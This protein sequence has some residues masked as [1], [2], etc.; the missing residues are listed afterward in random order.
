MAI[1]KKGGP[2]TVAGKAI[3]AKNSTKHGLTTQTPSSP[4]EKEIVNGYIQDLTAHY[5][6]ESPLERI[7]IERIAICKAKLDRLYEVER[8][9]LELATKKFIEDPNPILDQID[10]A[11]G[12]DR[13]MVME[14][15]K[16]GEVTLPCKLKDKDLEII[17]EE[18]LY[19]SDSVIKESD[20]EIYLP[21]LSNFLKSYEP[22]YLSDI[23]SGLIKRLDLVAQRIK[24]ALTKKGGYFEKYQDLLTVVARLREQSQPVAPAPSE[25]DLAFDK[26]IKEKKGAREIQG[27]KR[28]QNQKQLVAAVTSEQPIDQDKFTQQLGLFEE[29]LRVRNLSLVIY[30]QYQAIKDLMIEGVVLPQRDSDLLMRYQTTLDR[31][32]STAIGE[33]LHLQSKRI[34]S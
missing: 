12:L 21:N 10:M 11:K 14:L 26:F 7:Q 24:N 22:I 6:P 4:K 17:C 18:V 5:K 33:L 20:L 3:S 32:L 16:Y 13:G 15:I 29:L 28:Q 9:Q 23:D 19:C 34:P 8:V 1:K 30:K 25:D 27:Q 2:Q 31:R